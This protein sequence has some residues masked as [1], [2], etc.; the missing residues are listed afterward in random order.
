MTSSKTSKVVRYSNKIVIRW[1][2]R[3]L[4]RCDV[5]PHIQTLDWE[6]HE[7]IVLL[8]ACDLGIHGTKHSRSLAHASPLL[9]PLQVDDQY[10]WCLVDLQLLLNVS[11]LLANIAI[12]LIITTKCL[13]D[14]E[15]TET[16]GQIE[17]LAWLAILV[18]VAVLEGS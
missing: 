16:R 10:L 3:I 4:Q 15:G 2:L 12:P 13:L 8:C 18:G 17:S 1:V 9:E 14:R 11:M 7:S 5:R 6:V